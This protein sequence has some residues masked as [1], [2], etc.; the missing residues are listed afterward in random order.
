MSSVRPGAAGESKDDEAG[1]SGL[2]GRLF[3]K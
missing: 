2:L 1:K 3:K